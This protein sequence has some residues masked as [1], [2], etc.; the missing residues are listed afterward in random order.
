MSTE[1]A[2]PTNDTTETESRPD[3]EREPTGFDLP[4]CADIRVAA[5]VHERCMTALLARGE[6]R[7]G[8]GAVE[9][10]DAAVLQCLA[11]LA[12]GLAQGDRRL[13][14]ADRTPAFDRAVDLLGLGPVLGS[15]IET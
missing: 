5:E 2:A 13:D 12:I 15:G 11:A 10:V 14:L 3:E 8:C 6:V 7:I 4:A 1:V 9:R